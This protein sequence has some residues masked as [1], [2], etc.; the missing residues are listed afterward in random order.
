MRLRLFLT[1]CVL[2]GFGGF[3]GSVV[4]SLFGQ[5][6]LFIG[7][8]L[9]GVL[10][11]PLSAKLALWRSWIAPS[12]Y[13]PTAIGAAIGFVAAAVV[14][15]NTLSSPVGPALSPVLVGLGALAGSRWS[16][17]RTSAKQP[18]I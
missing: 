14:A 13:W 8:F 16:R 9:G 12:Q 15:V 7:G 5:T 2:G 10:V 11:A 18:S 4:G 3:L 6:A 1:T 17:N